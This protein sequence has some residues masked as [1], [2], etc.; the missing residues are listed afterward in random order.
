MYDQAVFRE[1]LKYGS[2][3]ALTSFGALLILFFTGTN[4]FGSN[5]VLTVITLTAAIFFG[6]SQFKKYT[7]PQLG[8]LK[9][10]S[11]ALTITATAAILSGSLVYGLARLAGKPALDRHIAEMKAV[12]Q[13]PTA[14]AKTIGIAG[15]AN[16]E[17]ALKN[18]EHIS[19]WDLAADDFYKKLGIGFLLSIVGATFFRK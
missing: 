5:L 15:K 3:C 18:L 6:L 8:F 4:P 16:Y 13:E 2:A 12:L 17:L 10:L 14:K 9:A 7:D 19:P 11:L 1:G